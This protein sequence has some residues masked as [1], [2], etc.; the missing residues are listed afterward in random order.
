MTRIKKI[1]AGA[2]LLLVGAA[3]AMVDWMGPRNVIGMLR[4]DQRAE[5]RLAV[6]DAA[7][8]VEL[9]ALGGERREKLSA[10]IG[11]RPLV[12]VFGSFT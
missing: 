9:F 8:D 11:D 7:P 5:G 10:Y 6:G 2:A 4:Y 12:L 3:G 1:I